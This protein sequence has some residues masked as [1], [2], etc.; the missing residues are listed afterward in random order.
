MRLAVS[1]N[2][3]VCGFHTRIRLRPGAAINRARRFQTRSGGQLCVGGAL[4]GDAASRGHRLPGEKR[5]AAGGLEIG[6]GV[7][8]GC[9]LGYCG[10]QGCPL[11][12]SQPLWLDR[13]CGWPLD[14]ASSVFGCGGPPN[15]RWH[16][17]SGFGFPR[18]GGDFW[19]LGPGASYA[20]C[21]RMTIGKWLMCLLVLVLVPSLACGDGISGQ[22]RW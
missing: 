22:T 13:P 11:S 5:C 6:G 12:W 1:L 14:G 17:C 18:F 19:Y 3:S 2:F 16:F 9:V 10:S 8:G 21:A 4:P 15:G 7:V 20:A